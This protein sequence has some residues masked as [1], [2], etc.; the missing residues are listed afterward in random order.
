MNFIKSNFPLLGVLVFALI[1]S[2]CA[3]YKLAGTAKPLPFSTLYIKPVQ[4]KSY[5]P[6]SAALVSK[7]LVIDLS[8]NADLEITLEGDSEAVLEVVL[9]NY[10]RDSIATRPDDT[11]LASSVSQELSARCSLI[12]KRTGEYLFKDKIVSYQ[13]VVHIPQDGNLIGSEYQNMPILARGLARKIADEVL[14]IW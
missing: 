4:N 3:N 12:N 2:A 11:A 10:S 13:N 7:Q 5:A 1:L 6:Q 8:E 9:E 14:G